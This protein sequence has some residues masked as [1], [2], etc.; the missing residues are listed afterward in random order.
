MH[1]YDPERAA[2]RFIPASTFKVWN[3]LAALETGVVP[4]VDSVFQWDGQVRDVPAWNRDHSL[5]TAIA[6]SAV[7]VYQ[8]VARRIGPDGYRAM[9]ALEPYGNGDFRGPIDYFWLNGPLRISADEQVAFLDRLRR[10]ALAFAP[11]HQAAVRDILL[12]DEHDGTRL[13]GKTGWTSTFDGQFASAYWSGPDVGWFVG[14]VE[15]PR[16]PWVFALNIEPDPASDVPLDIQPARL[17]ITYDVLA[18]LGLYTPE[19]D[20]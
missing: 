4:D 14:W 17:D 12:L 11:E 7:W 6:V 1:R 16:G 18:D 20:D 8:E 15:T 10:G 5:R 19:A 3:S 2:Q 9:F 13:Y